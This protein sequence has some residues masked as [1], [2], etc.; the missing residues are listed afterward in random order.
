VPAHAAIE[1]ILPTL[2]VRDRAGQI[3]NRLPEVL[4]VFPRERPRV[5][6]VGVHRIA[7]VLR[8]L[9]RLATRLAGRSGL[10]IPGSWHRLCRQGRRFC[11]RLCV[12][13]GREVDGAVEVVERLFGAFEAEEA[14]PAVEEVADALRAGL[15]RARERLER[16]DVAPNIGEDQRPRF[17]EPPVGRVEH[18]RALD[19]VLRLGVALQRAEDEGLVVEGGDERPVAVDG[20]SVFVIGELEL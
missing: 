5:Q 1:K 13:G 11:E 3:R 12:L 4:Q 15:D 8:L 6:Q 14:L 20:V 7:V 9:G 10:R 19:G 17:V 18:D 2:F 16:L